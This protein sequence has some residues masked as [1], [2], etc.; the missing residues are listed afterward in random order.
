M[1]RT[2]KRRQRGVRKLGDVVNDLLARRGYAQEQ[3][4]VVCQTAWRSAVGERIGVDTRVGE[5][6]RGV[7]E[8][9]VRNSAVMQE[10]TFQKKQILAALAASVS[11]QT[12][13][14]LR[15]RVGGVD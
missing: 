2:N 8:V 13:R 15:L 3:Q 9:M 1:N 4:A 10:I 5:I 12:I 6:R 14:D 11:E 7:L